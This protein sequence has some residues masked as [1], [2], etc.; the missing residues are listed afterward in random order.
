ML[1]IILLVLL[2]QDIMAKEIGKVQEEIR[3]LNLVNGLELSKPQMEFIMDRAK[4]VEKMRDDCRQNIGY[5]ENT[6]LWTFNQLKEN[7]INDQMTPDALRDKVYAAE[8]KIHDYKV[9]LSES[10]DKIAQEVENELEGNQTY[11]LEHYIPCLIP[12]P[13][14]ES[15]IGQ[16]DKPVG[17]TQQLEKVREMPDYQYETK[18]YDIANKVITRIKK[19]LASG[20]RFDENAEQKRILDLFEELRN[21]SGIDFA[22]KQDEY[23]ERLKSNYFVKKIP[24][25]VSAK[26]REFLL[27]P[28]IIPILEEKLENR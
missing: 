9:T 13:G 18:K 5:Y 3:I 21:L 27:N 19:H 1:P 11:Q 6:L 22:L 10:I 17:I 12:P 26:I 8:G 23:V 7:R 20:M 14:S 2:N 16:S 25:D 15:R 28:L 4:Q 24:V